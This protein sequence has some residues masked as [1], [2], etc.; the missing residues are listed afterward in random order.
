MEQCFLTGDDGGAWIFD[1]DSL[2]RRTRNGGGLELP[3]LASLQW[4]CGL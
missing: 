2:G 1:G 4:R 3:D